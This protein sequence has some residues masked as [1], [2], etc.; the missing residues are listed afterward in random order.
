MTYTA[1]FQEVRPNLE[2]KQANSM[3]YLHLLAVMMTGGVLLEGGKLTEN[4]KTL[5]CTEFIGTHSRTEC[6]LVLYV[7]L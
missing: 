5:Q 2:T 1:V 7:F 4:N 3:L 6:M